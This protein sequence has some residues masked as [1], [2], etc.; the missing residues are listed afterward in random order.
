MRARQFGVAAVEFAIIL[1]VLL[2]VAF[3]IVE[4]GRAMYEYDSLVKN[5]RAA[6]RYLSTADPDVDTNRNRA[7][8]I[9]KA[10]DPYAT[11]FVANPPVNPNPAP[12][13][14]P[15][16]TASVDVLYAANSNGLKS[17]STGADTGT[18][19]LVTVVVRGYEYQSLLLPFIPPIAAFGPISATM[20]RLGT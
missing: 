14:G 6:A 2:S 5:T 11:C 7:A 13:L 20:V 1:P 4:F 19:D 8:C 16:K 10:A 9:V 18:V 15:L 17:V 12:W 3:G